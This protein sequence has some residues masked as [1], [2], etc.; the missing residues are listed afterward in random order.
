MSEDVKRQ[1][2]PRLRELHRGKPSG[3]TVRVCCRE[4][5]LAVRGQVP[6]KNGLLLLTALCKYV[7]ICLMNEDSFSVRLGQ[8]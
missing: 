5:L 3:E 8:C 2:K 1:N 7:T 4:V 6:A